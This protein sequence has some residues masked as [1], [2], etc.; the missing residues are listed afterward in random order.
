H[1][2]RE[3]GKAA[4][5]VLQHVTADAERFRAGRGTGGVLRIVQAAQRADA[6]DPRDLAARTAGSTQDRLALDIDAVGQR[7]PDRY[8]HHALA[9]AIEA[10]GDVAAEHIVDADDR[11]AL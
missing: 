2:M 7:I 5:A 4:Q 6:A 10:I 8:A 1:A 3:A 9:R 11:G